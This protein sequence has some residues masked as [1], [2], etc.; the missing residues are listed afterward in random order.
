MLNSIIKFFGYVFTRLS[1]VIGI[2]FVSLFLV[3]PAWC[4]ALAVLDLFNLSIT[5]TCH[6]LYV[7]LLSGLL[8]FVPMYIY[9]EIKAH[10]KI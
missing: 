4:L 2:Y 5:F 10:E 3:S 8:L 7:W 9:V 1:I 6:F